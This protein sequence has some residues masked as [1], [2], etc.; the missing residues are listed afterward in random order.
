[1]GTNH[2]QDA[3]AQSIHPATRVGMVTLSV[4]SLDRSEAFYTQVLGLKT[5]DRSNDRLALGVG[6]YPLLE[7][8]EQPGA[9][10]L[11]GRTGLYH[12]AVLVPDRLELARVLR[13]LLEQQ[14]T[15][16]GFADHHVS[17]AIYLPDPDGHGIEIYRDRP[18][19]AWLDSQGRFLMTTDPLDV[20]G[21]LAELPREYKAE[22]WVGMPGETTMGHI[23][24]HVRDLVEGREFY[25]RL[26]GFD[27][28]LDWRSAAFLSAGGYHHHIGINTWAGE[29]APPAEP[30]S[31]RLIEYE[32]V[33]PDQGAVKSV[34]QRLEAAGYTYQQEDSRALLQDPSANTIVLRAS[35]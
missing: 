19:S 28:M 27:L 20:Q 8:R 15:L 9:T 18:R 35:A 24:L 2:T 7:L 12:F 34:L 17:E 1:M 22:S 21:L 3:E 14:V 10:H 31:L 16:T 32:L 11:S 6:S 26:L 25:H 5:I 33:L 13:N 23:H 29:Q 30:D 4:S